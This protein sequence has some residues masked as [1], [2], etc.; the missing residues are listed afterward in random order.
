MEPNNNLYLTGRYIFWIARIWTALA[1]A[2][3]LFMI[4]GHIFGSEPQIIRN[5]EWIA[6]IFFPAGVLTGLLI[7]L[8]RA[9]P[10]ALITLI[11]MLVFFALSPAALGVIW[12]WLLV[13][14]AAIYLIHQLIFGRIT[15]S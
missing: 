3:L 9:I 6:M 4:A 1:A 10:G 15:A 13:A 12:F 7:S 11:S 2:F 8:I 5:N 14:P